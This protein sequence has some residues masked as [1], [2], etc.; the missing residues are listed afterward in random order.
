LYPKGANMRIALFGVGGVGGYFGG[1]LVRAGQEVVFVARGEHLQALQRNGLWVESILG[2]FTVSPLQAVNDP[3]QVGKVDVI[4]LGVKAWQVNMA[5]F[6]LRPMLSAHTC[7]VPLQNGVD[8]PAQ[9]AKV[10]GAEHVLGGLCQISAIKV[11]PGHIRHVG[12]E[13]LISF[14]ELNKLPSQRVS[15]LRLAFEQAGVKVTT[16]GDI[17]TAMWGKF[18]FIAAI[19]GVG[20]LTRAPIG[21]TRSLP[22]TRQLLVGA[23]QEIADLAHEKNIPLDPEI[24]SKT[25][26]FI[27]KMA[28]HIVPSM[29]RDIL[30]GSPSELAA[31]NGAVVRMGL[32]TGVPTPTHAFI[33]ASLL[34]QELH[35]RGEIQF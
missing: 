24:V 30:E 9:L 8:A 4:L 18:L 7:V 2:D 28:P 21:V 22:E 19:S 25:L 3:Q 20:A 32:E 34:P 29:Q 11:G 10:L 26:V 5:A 33:Y 35:A 6:E 12:I 16:P 1:Q 14:G 13:P 15:D 17:Q 27:D 23:M 31:Q